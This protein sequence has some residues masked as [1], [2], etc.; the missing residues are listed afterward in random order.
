MMGDQDRVDRSRVYLGMGY[1]ITNALLV[2]AAFGSEIVGPAPKGLYH[3]NRFTRRR[4]PCKY[5]YE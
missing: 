1:V 3:S 5:M 2:C 4:W